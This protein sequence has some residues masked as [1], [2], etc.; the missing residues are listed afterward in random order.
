ME[1]ERSENRTTLSEV[2]GVLLEMLK[3]LAAFC[4]ANGLRYYLYCGTLLGAVRHK[5]FIPWDDDVDIVMPLKDYRRFIRL[6]RRGYPGGFEVETLANSVGSSVPWVKIY[7][8]G[9]TM[10]V[11]SEAAYETNW[12]IHLDIYPM[13][14][15]PSSPRLASLQKKL[16]MA[17]KGLLRL[18]LNAATGNWGREHIPL[19]KKMQ[20]VP[21]LIR[22]AAAR[23]FLRL[24]L[25]PPEKSRRAGSVD[26]A[27]FCLKY[28]RTWWDRTAKAEFEDTSFVI[29][30]EYD[31]ILTVMYGDY[32][33]PPPRDWQYGHGEA[34]GD[35]I[36]DVRRDYREYREELL[37]RRSQ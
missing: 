23:C 18:E 15:G 2:H 29:P 17:A 12:G 19:K 14:G 28:D 3:T 7:K 31:K 37:G 21:R 26:A 22:W 34:I 35:V 9:T 33:T 36:Y 1:A 16:I 11:R 5:G 6:A 27:E 20:K 24:A 13:S 10:L 4:E 30:A 32:M 25:R 8:P